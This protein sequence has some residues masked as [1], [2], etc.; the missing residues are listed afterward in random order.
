M[1]YDNTAS[2]QRYNYAAHHTLLQHLYATVV[3]SAGV[4]TCQ[5]E[6]AC[7]LQQKPAKVCKAGEAVKQQKLKMA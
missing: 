3:L 2:P 7:M 1:Q 5:P 4:D 6:T